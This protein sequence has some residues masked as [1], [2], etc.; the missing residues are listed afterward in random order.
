MSLDVRIY[1][2]IIEELNKIQYEILGERYEDQRY[3]TA[4]LYKI[5]SILKEVVTAL[6]KRGKRKEEKDNE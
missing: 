1:D 5:C 6:P 3:M 2:A 4:E